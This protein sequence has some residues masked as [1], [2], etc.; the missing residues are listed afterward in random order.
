MCQC[1]EEN[2]IRVEVD[3]FDNLLVSSSK[4]HELEK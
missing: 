4:A 1:P 3:A 2:L